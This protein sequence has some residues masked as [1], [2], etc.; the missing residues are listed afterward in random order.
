M[1]VTVE[2]FIGQLRARSEGAGSIGRFFATLHDEELAEM[3]MGLHDEGRGGELAMAIT[4]LYRSWLTELSPK[5]RVR[6]EETNRTRPSSDQN[7]LLTD[8]FAD[9]AMASR[10]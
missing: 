4:T 2:D 1:A 10:S 3:E 8:I 9:E 7:G 5:D 6:L